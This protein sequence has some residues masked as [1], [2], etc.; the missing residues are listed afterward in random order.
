MAVTEKQVST[1]RAQCK[2]TT[3]EK[4]TTS[5]HGGS[6]NY[7]GALFVSMNNLTLMQ[8]IPTGSSYAAQVKS[9]V[10]QRH[11]LPFSAFVSFFFTK[12]DCN[13]ASQQSTDRS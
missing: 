12:E 9:L 8:F 3:G 4:L 10:E 1:R 6:L 13:L 7:L 5:K 2:D 11:G